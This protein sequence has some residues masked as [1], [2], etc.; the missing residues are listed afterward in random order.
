ML[1]DLHTHTF[2]N[3]DDSFVSPDELVDAA[4]GLGLD[5][6]C[7]TEH[8]YFWDPDDIRALSRRHGF[9]VLPGCEVNT[10]G[11][12]V[13]VLGLKEYVF[14]MHKAAFLRKLVE[15]AGGVMMAAH[16]YRRRYIRDGA[17]RSG[18]YWAMVNNACR[19]D[20]FSLCDAIEML[21]GRATDDETVFSQDLCRRLGLGAV[22]G[23]DSHR[24]TQLG[25]VATR[26]HGKITCLE[27]LI[28]ELKTGR[29]EPAT[30]SG[31]SA[32][33]SPVEQTGGYCIPT[34]LQVNETT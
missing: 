1:I 10:D 27:D 29:F 17:R 24:L 15:W 12:H 23:S 34:A 32:P 22:G 6:I 5:G 13:L 9:L 26:F 19:D 28:G 33:N 14:G 16:P 3:S 18:D 25:N 20:F 30:L 8:D 11:G 21:N 31:S 4:K 2:P 7:I